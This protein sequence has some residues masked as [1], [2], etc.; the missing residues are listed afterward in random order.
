MY[1]SMHSPPTQHMA[2]E[3]IVKT[4]ES[5]HRRL[6][7]LERRAAQQRSLATGYDSHPIITTLVSKA[8]TLAYSIME[9]PEV[10]M[11]PNI[12]ED[13]QAELKKRQSAINK[14]ASEVKQEFPGVDPTEFLDAI[15]Q[16]CKE[17]DKWGFTL[18]TVQAIIKVMGYSHESHPVQSAYK[19]RN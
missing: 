15:G 18:P 12:F 2:Q 13:F 8:H 6:D 4:I 5:L 10:D 9:N 7:A 16:E 14:I 3:A 1:L 11:N 17:Q 19:R